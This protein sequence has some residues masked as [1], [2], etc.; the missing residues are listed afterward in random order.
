MDEAESSN[1]QS[2]LLV[3][4]FGEGTDETVG[5]Q[6]D[7]GQFALGGNLD[8]GVCELKG[9]DRRPLVEAVVVVVLVEV[10]IVV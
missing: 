8:E 5:G 2:K 7:G 1:H 3:L 6:C 4:A 10:V 9:G